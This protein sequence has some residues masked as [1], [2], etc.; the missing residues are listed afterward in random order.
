MAV[1]LALPELATRARHELEGS[2]GRASKGLRFLS[3][4]GRPPVGQTPKDVVWSAG[5][6]ELWRYRSN[7]RTG[8]RPVLFVHSLVSRTYIA[9]LTPGNSFVEFMLARGLDVFLV[10]WGVP[11]E[12]EAAN[13]LETYCDELLPELVEVTADVAEADSVVLFAYCLGAVLTLLYCAGH[14]DDRFSALAVMATPVDFHQM[15]LT[16]AIRRGTLNPQSLLDPT[17]NVP[18]ELMLNALRMLRPTGPLSAYAS[19]W[20][21]VENDTIVGAHQTMTQ[22]GRDHIPFPGQCFLQVAELFAA[23]NR[24]PTGQVPLG[25]RVVDLKDITVPFLNIVGEHD[26]IV[27]PAVTGELTSLVGSTEVD[28][29]RLRAGHV[30]LIVGG[31]A[32]RHNLPVMADWLERQTN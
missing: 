29:L 23:Q 19:L 24:L 20:Q 3:G 1:R 8:G 6:V 12:L 27:P 25:D 31:A 16:A 21:H 32:H 14:P 7:R 2:L 11:D 26:H 13:T 30:G 28:E 22:W 18:P 9:D 15:P 17:G 10:D 4:V 5:K